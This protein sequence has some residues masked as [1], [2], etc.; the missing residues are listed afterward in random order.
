MGNGAPAKDSP[1]NSLSEWIHI[2]A[3]KLRCQIG[4]PD[5]ERAAP[6]EILLD[7]SLQPLNSFQQM[8]DR[9]DLTVDYAS[10]ADELI[11]LA[12]SRPRKLIET[13]AADIARWTLARHPVAAVSVQIRKFILPNT[14]YVGVSLEWTREDIVQ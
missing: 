6:Q 13:L 8:Q 14:D 2:R 5:E 11:N 4:V 9:I 10:L 3:L 12:A 1:Q 7:L